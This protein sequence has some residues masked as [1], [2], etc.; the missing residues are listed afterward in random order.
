[1]KQGRMFHLYPNGKIEYFKGK[2]L[3]NTMQLTPE[4]RARKISRTEMEIQVTAK[5][6]KYVLLQE[7]LKKMPPRKE[8]ESC[9][10]DD[11]IEYIN[12]VSKNLKWTSYYNSN[13]I[14]QIF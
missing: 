13:K 4:S 5:G 10:L 14:C 11:W 1:M 3:A 8:R 9:L 2:E 12:E 7:D 6:R